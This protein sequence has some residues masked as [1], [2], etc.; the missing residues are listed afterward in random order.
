MTRSAPA[1]IEAQPVTLLEAALTLPNLACS[2]VF[3]IT[4]KLSLTGRIV[5]RRTCLAN[6]RFGRSPAWKAL[7][8][9]A[10]SGRFARSTRFRS[11]R[12]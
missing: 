6:D 12:L 5:F 7:C 8:Q 1:S 2:V 10:G 3:P 9:E 4:E 11:G